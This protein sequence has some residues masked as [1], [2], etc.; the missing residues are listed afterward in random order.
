MIK[1][2]L[3]PIPSELTPDV[4]LALTEKF[5]QDKN[6]RVWTQDYIRNAL[7]K[8]S[9]NKCCY[10]ECKINVNGT[11]LN[12][13]HFHP[14]HLYPDEV[15][16]WD[17]LLPSCSRCNTKKE[18]VDTKNKKY[19][20]IHPVKNNPKQHLKVEQYYFSHKDDLGEFTIEKLQLNDEI[21]LAIDRFQLGLSV[22]KN[23]NDLTK[24]IANY[25]ENKIDLT[26][27]QEAII[28][29]K[30]TEIMQ[31]GTANKKY[32]AVIATVILTNS[33]YQKIKQFF[34]S[35]NLWND[36]FTELEQQVEFCALI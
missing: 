11:P 15:V 13:E 18:K 22:T 34:E 17:N 4:V 7:L 26:A 28:C 25:F 30:L 19:Q 6:N 5:K 9:N 3:E 2:M 29:R 14:K 35:N 1:L 16:T 10:C 36:E 27:I 8:M 20:I 23:L 21:K 12:V 32:S 24:E 31:F 33:D